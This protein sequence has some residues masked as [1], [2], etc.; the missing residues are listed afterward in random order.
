MN[1][2]IFILISMFAALNLFA[3]PDVSTQETNV[4]KIENPSTEESKI[5]FSFDFGMEASFEV[6]GNDG[7]LAFD[8]FCFDVKD[9]TFKTE[10]ALLDNLAFGFYIAAPMTLETTYK[11]L[12]NVVKVTEVAPELGVELTFNPSDDITLE[13][14]LG[15][16]LVFAPSNLEVFSI[17]AGL[18]V[19]AEISY[20]NSFFAISV[21]DTLNPNWRMT[22]VEDYKSFIDNELE[23]ELTFDF[24]NF[25]KKDLNTGLWL[26]NDL[27]TDYYFDS[28]DKYSNCAFENELFAGLHTAPV[29]WFEAKAAFYGDFV[30]E[31]DKDGKI[32]DGSDTA[33]LGLF[34]EVAFS[35]KNIGFAVSY[36]PILYT[37]NAET[38]EN[39][40]HEVSAAISV[41]F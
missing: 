19:S 39:T 26:S 28:N 27:V 14:G 36:N 15:H 4:T 7:K 24:L 22:K 38:P 12:I 37:V 16:N 11:D 35:Y 8:S 9:L 41:S 40:S 25:V 10:I 20:E 5:S 31:S 2:K 17:D 23:I 33:G 13:F 29:E 30:F 21:A 32:V 3:Q 18:L 34:L 1:K 6:S